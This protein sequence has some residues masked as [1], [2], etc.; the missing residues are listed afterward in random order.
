MKKTGILGGTFDPIHIGHIA[1]ARAALEQYALDEVLVM[2]GG[3]PPHKRDR[4][5]TDASLRNEM[6]ECALKNERN[7][8]PFDYEVRKQDYSY[9]AKTLTELKELHHDWQIYFIIGEDSLYD[10]PE[11]YEPETVCKNAILLVFPRTENSQLDMLIKNRSKELN[12]DIRKI[13]APLVDVSSTDIR[14]RIKADMDISGLVSDGVEEYIREK[15][16]YK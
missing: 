13:D 7:I 15:G 2:A 10:L 14:N 16:L 1:L 8:T 6:V 3:N 4:E 5:I 9:T 12:A 11:W